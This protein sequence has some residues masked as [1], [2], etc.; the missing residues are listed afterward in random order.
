VRPLYTARLVGEPTR[1]YPIAGKSTSANLT[2]LLESMLAQNNRLS[3]E[4]KR[5]TVGARCTRS[6]ICAHIVRLSLPCLLL[7]LFVSQPSGRVS[8]SSERASHV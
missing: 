4:C 7:F 8:R 5:S 1:T 3:P 6:M 2:N